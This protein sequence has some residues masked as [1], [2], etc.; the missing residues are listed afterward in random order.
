MRW[1]PP[2]DWPNVSLSRQIHAPPHRWHVQETGAGPC[3]LMLHG[4]GGSVHSFRDMLGALAAHYRVIAIDLPG[5]GFTR[6]G[7]R[8]RCG[9]DPMA[10]D[11]EKLCQQ[12]GWQPRAI[13]GHSAG[14]ALALKLSQ[15]LRTAEGEVPQ[16][17][18][19]NPA[20][21]TFDGIAGV[22]FPAIAKMLAAIPFSAS[23]FSATSAT[24]SRI[25]TLLR[26][27]GSVLDAGGRALYQ[28]LVAD[29]DH[30]DG[31][32]LMM[33]QWS[34][35]A[36]VRSLPAL[37]TRTL[38]IIGLRDGAVPPRVARDAASRMAD[39][40][41]IEFPDHG[42]LVHEEVADDIARHVSAFLG[43]RSSEGTQP[44]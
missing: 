7:A 12:E 4:A 11:I 8:H 29:R 19:I 44:R 6:L 33:S 32:L 24:P 30:V 34:L 36:L 18:G 26:G 35:D 37:E 22:L 27:T 5:Q 15:T 25:E 13:I 16:V 31:T 20:L 1:P 21:D 43:D 10:Q 14:S 28:R 40:R 9:L 41:V 39:A 42:H 23:V 2:S 17:V 38:F 3:L